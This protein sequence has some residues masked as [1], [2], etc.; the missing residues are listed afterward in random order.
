MLKISWH[1]LSEGEIQ[2]AQT[3]ECQLTS[4]SCALM[5]EKGMKQK[6]NHMTAKLIKC[7]V[8][9]KYDSSSAVKRALKCKRTEKNKREAKQ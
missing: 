4:N 1:G 6:F 2:E 9:N 5:T 8:N 3:P 7:N